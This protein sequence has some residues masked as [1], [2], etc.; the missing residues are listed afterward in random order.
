MEDSLTA[1]S[2]VGD[3]TKQLRNLQMELK[4]LGDLLTEV[5][6]IKKTMQF[7]NHMFGGNLPQCQN[8]IRRPELKGPPGQRR[9]IFAAPSKMRMKLAVA[10]TK[11]I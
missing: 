3:F 11:F 7:A 10:V 8:Q 5:K 4:E 2:Q 6:A 1:L 9:W